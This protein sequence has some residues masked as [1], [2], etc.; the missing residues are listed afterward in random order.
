VLVDLA[1]TEEEI[2][3]RMKEKWRYNIRLASKKGVEVRRLDEAGLDAFLGL[4]R[5]TARRDRI[6]VHGGDYYAGLFALGREYGEGSPELRLYAAFHEGEALG[7]VVTLFRGGEG[8]YL[9]GASS[10]RKRNLMAP[11]L[12]QWTAMREAKAAGCLYYDLFGIPPRDD[13]AH[14][15]AGLYRFKT[16]FIGGGRGGRIIHRPGSWDFVRRPLGAGLFGA[17]EFLR[18]KAR[19]LRRKSAPF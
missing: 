16:G 19:N 11:Y 12:L 15:M 10:G 17:A 6:A 18:K 7:A 14:P 2:L 8:V 13:P 5:E 9:Y 4:L 3:S 1:G